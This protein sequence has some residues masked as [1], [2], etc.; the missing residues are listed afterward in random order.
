VYN[1]HHQT[2]RRKTKGLFFFRAVRQS[3]LGEIRRATVDGL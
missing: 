3:A 1:I 2:K